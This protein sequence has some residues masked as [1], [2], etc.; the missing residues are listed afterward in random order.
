MEEAGEW[1]WPDWAG[2]GDELAEG[3]RARMA[4]F[5]CGLC[6]GGGAGEVVAVS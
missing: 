3:V 1:N 6:G 5:W 4:G 2:G